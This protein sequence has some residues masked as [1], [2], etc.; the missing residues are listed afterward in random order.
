MS[1]DTVIKKIQDKAAA[2]ADAI[3]KAGKDEA[4]A[5]RA[6]VMAEAQKKADAI[7]QR[8]K[9]QADMILRGTN[10]QAEL[11]N[12]IGYLNCKH[13]LLDKLREAAKQELTKY[14]NK[15]WGNLYTKLVLENA[16]SGEI[17]IQASKKDLAKFSDKSFCTKTFNE[18]GLLA[19]YWSKLLTDK[20]NESVSI[21]VSG[22]PVDIDGGI[23]LCGENY[24]ID[25]SFDAILDEVFEQNENEI[26][27]CLFGTKASAK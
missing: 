17:T 26:A 18:K 7:V 20:R 19:E 9:A 1:A 8:G 13:E 24:D 22:E 27:G 14:D 6:S 12:K 23:I 15:K 5:L 10:Q 2:E 11:D 25:L 16:M 3:T 4:D 21:A